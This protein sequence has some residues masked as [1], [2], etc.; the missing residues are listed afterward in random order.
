MNRREA[1]QCRI[2]VA[3]WTY[4]VGNTQPVSSAAEASA[5]KGVVRGLFGETMFEGPVRD[6]RQD[7]WEDADNVRRELIANADDV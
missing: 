7:A 3:T 2:E 1:R 5:F 4:P 6:L